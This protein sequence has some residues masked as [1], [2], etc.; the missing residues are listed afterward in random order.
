[1]HLSIFHLYPARMNLYG[2]RGNVLALVRRAEWRGWTVEVVPVEVGEPADFARADLIFMGG[3]EDRHQAAIFEDFR[4]RGPEIRAAL[5]DG[6]PALAICGAYQL[7][8]HYYETAAGQR[9]DGLGWF[10]AYTRPGPGRA[11]GNVVV[12]A[13]LPLEPRTLVGFEN[14]GGR[15]YLEPGQAPLGRVVAGAGNNGADGTEGAVK[16]ATVGTYLHGSLL[17]KNPQLADWLL[18]Q[19]Q[20]RREGRAQLEP[21]DDTL[22][23]WAHEG[24]VE[25][26]R[27]LTR[28][29]NG[30]G[31]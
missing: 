24:A 17:P 21:L 18:A 26:T 10:A 1:V 6:V 30:A 27:R 31:R 8:G 7:L 22:E 28:V 29:K 12:E 15:T 25:R 11:I 2:D 13:T 20:E 3:G 5:A 23:L 9:L 16:L 19:A 4:R 14:H